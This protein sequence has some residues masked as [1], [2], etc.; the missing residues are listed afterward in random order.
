MRSLALLPV[1]SVRVV[2]GY[3]DRG[4]SRQGELAQLVAHTVRPLAPLRPRPAPDGP[5]A[6]AG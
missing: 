1:A 5:P 6:V 4:R 2:L 3:Y